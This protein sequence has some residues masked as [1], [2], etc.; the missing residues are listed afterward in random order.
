[1]TPFLVYLHRTCL[2]FG[3]PLV[4]KPYNASVFLIDSE[5]SVEVLIELLE[6]WYFNQNV[7]MP[8][9]QTLVTRYGL[10]SYYKVFPHFDL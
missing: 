8:N 1:M 2:T 9:K 7:P 4:R 5:K 10:L 6:D 3:K